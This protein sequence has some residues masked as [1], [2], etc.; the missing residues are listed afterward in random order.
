VNLIFWK[1]NYTPASGGLLIVVS[2]RL[3][4]ARPSTTLDVYGHQIPGM[5]AQAIELIDD[6][7]SPIQLHQTAPETTDKAIPQSLHPKL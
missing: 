7:I 5:Q 4:H 1:F 3:G 6:V 2:I